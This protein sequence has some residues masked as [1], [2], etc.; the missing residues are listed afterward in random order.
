M[1]PPIDYLIFPWRFYGKVADSI[2]LSLK[3]KKACLEK[4][5]STGQFESGQAQQ[6]SLQSHDPYFVLNVFLC[7]L[8]KPG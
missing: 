8:M 3:L 1:T 4:V 2:S 7:D 5:E 6:Q